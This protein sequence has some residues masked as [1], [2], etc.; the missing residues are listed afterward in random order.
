MTAPDSEPMESFLDTRAWIFDLDNTL[1]PAQCN[2]FAQIDQRMGKFIADYLDLPFDDARVLQKSYYVGYGTTLAGLMA[3]H[4]LKP[5]K[6]L[7]YVHDIDVSMLSPSP[8]LATAIERLPG[9]KYIF[10][11]GS[12]DHA[13]NVAGQLG[14]LDKF[15]GVFDIGDAGFVPKPDPTAYDKFLKAH[16][17][18]AH[19]AAMFED[20]P[21]N[22]KA[23]HALG[24]VTVLVHSEY[25]D[26]PIQKQIKEWVEPP[27]HIHHMTENLLGFLGDVHDALKAG[28]GAS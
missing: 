2:L 10:T 16:N 23:P 7:D 24:M 26:H 13:E 1:Y 20:M 25:Y 9:E 28:K 12:Q 18:T 6:F 5:E 21:H 14:V 11:N 27:E 17:V 15:D 8:E 22:L 19:E 4:G 3:E